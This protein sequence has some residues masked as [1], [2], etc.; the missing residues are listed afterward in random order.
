MN[1]FVTQVSDFDIPDIDTIGIPIIE[2]VLNQE[3]EDIKGKQYSMRG[4]TGYHS[5]DDLASRNED[6]SVALKNL[7]HA[8]IQEH[9]AKLPFVGSLFCNDV[10]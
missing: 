5:L 8:M 2:H 10:W 6:W 1:L 4:R 9:A 3:K 7:L